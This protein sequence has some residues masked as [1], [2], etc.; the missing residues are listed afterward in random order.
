MKRK[1]GKMTKNCETKKKT[2]KKL[3]CCDIKD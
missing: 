2:E 3:K 1:T